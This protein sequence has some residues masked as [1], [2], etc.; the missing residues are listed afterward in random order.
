MWILCITGNSLVDAGCCVGDWLW[1]GAWM[2]AGGLG[3]GKEHRLSVP[4]ESNFVHRYGCSL[5]GVA[6][7]PSTGDPQMGIDT[8]IAQNGHDGVS[9]PQYYPHPWST[10]GDILGIKTD[11]RRRGCARA[12]FVE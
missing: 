12:G 11:L 9:Y 1:V 4:S 6:V 7:N 8:R 2:T 3:I 5:R 10:P